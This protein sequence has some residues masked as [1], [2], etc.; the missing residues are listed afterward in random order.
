MIGSIVAS[1]FNSDYGM[2]PTL[3]KRLEKLNA[4]RSRFLSALN[5]VPED[6]LNSSPQP[7]VWSPLEVAEHTYRSERAMLRALERQLDPDGERREVGD[8]SRIRVSALMLAM[9]APT[10][11]KV[12]ASAGV[13]PKGISLE[14]MRTDWATFEERWSKLI[15]DFP[16]ELATTGLVRHPYSGA[17]T[18]SQGIQFLALH[19]ARHLKQLKRVVNL[20]KSA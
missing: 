18:A 12:P 16:E 17:L 6:L 14:E 8:P 20:L 5:R 11:F 9:R 15:E 10:K 7:G 3:P 4:A 19:T 13:A 2:I 1:L